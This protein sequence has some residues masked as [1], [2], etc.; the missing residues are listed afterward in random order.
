MI[1]AALPLFD[2][3]ESRAARDAGIALVTENSGGFMP[4]ALLLVSK[5]GP[6]EYIGED[7][8][9]ACNAAG[10]FPHHPNA[11]GSLIRTAIKRGYLTPTGDLDPMKFVKSHA[12]KSMVYSR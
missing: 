1:D 5:L 7:V 8:R 11:W 6:G 2:A 3:A 4:L 10:L 9:R 12:R